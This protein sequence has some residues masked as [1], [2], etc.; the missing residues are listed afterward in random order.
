[1]NINEAFNL[2]KIQTVH[3]RALEKHI[4]FFLPSITMNVFII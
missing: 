3:K 1:M 4:C 2:D